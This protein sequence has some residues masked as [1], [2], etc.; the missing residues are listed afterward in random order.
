MDHHIDKMVACGVPINKAQKAYKTAKERVALNR[1][2]N[3]SDRFAS[4][5]R[6]LNMPYICVHTPAALISEDIVQKK[7]DEKIGA[8]PKAKLKDVLDAIN[9]IDEYIKSDIK[10]VIRVGEEKCYAG[11]TYVS[12]SGGTNGGAGVLKAYYEAGVGTVVQMHATDDD[13]KAVKEQG[14]GHLI[15]TPHMASDSI[16]M[17][18]ILNEWEK[19]GVEVVV[20]SGIV[21]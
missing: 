20:M 7:I 6:L 4:A 16:G 13:I 5:A 14:L 9:E 18:I 10:A 11:K 15:V 1:H 12:M 19:M 2:T 3:N 17:N 21:R 8:N